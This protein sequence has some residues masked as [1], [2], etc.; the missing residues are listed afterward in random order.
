MQVM[1]TKELQHLPH[2]VSRASTFMPSSNID[3]PV[4]TL[5]RVIGA[6]HRPMKMIDVISLP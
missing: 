3:E 4:K 6:L 1:D 5:V 2:G